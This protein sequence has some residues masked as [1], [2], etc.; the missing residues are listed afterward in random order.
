MVYILS[1]FPRAGGTFRAFGQDYVFGVSDG[2]QA[3]DRRT[4]WRLYGGRVSVPEQGLESVQGA[5]TVSV[6]EA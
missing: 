4:L 5:G 1:R 6:S 2:A 3:V